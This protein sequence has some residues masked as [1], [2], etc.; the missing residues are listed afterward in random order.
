MNKKLEEKLAMLAF[1][2]MAP[3]EAARLEN[4]MRGDPDAER[5]LEQYRN[6]RLDLHA[7]AN[8]PEHQLSTER[9]RHAIL[10]QGLKPVSR[11][12]WGW[13]WMPAAAAVLA[14]GL[15]L[16]RGIGSMPGLPMSGGPVASS[17]GSDLQFPQPRLENA[18]AFATASAQ[19]LSVAKTE[20]AAVVPPRSHRRAPN[21]DRLAALRDAVNQE[22]ENQMMASISPTPR[23][24]DAKN[25]PS[26]APIVLIDGSQDSSTG[27]LK[28]SE[29]DSTSNVVVGG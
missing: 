23:A 2:D 4:E 1:G 10:N 21:V 19:I 7:M 24:R 14:V 9:L 18:F 3:E 13:L 29:V 8:V 20:P 22:F 25:P 28:A 5:I 11:P 15:V 12:R 16:A 17:N 6:M 26:G 27:T